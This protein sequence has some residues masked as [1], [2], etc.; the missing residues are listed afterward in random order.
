MFDPTK[1]YPTKF[2]L[3]SDFILS[4]Y[5]MDIERLP[6][7]VFEA[8]D[9]EAMEKALSDRIIINTHYHSED[10]NNVSY[11][12]KYVPSIK[13]THKY[14]TVNYS[15]ATILDQR[16]EGQSGDQNGCVSRGSYSS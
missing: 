11:T 14:E 9:M 10:N 3:L 16:R 5:D 1:H 6:Y 7:P 2:D 13:T 15:T 12:A 8:L 4:S